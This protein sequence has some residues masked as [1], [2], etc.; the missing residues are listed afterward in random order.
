MS[1]AVGTLNDFIEEKL[2]Q[3]HTSTIARVERVNNN[4]TYDVQPLIMTKEVGDDDGE[5]LP[6]LVD[7]PA[8]GFKG[9][10][11]G[12]L[13]EI[14]PAYEKGDIVVIAFAERAFDTALTGR[15]EL[16]PDFRRHSLND[17]YITGVF[18]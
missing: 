2:L 17:A 15:E 3:L 1:R 8:T 14:E 16:P 13:K 6:L 18:L 10:I 5:L 12:S 9:K 11:D 4:K 7:V